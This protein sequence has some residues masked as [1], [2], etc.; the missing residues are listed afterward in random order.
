[1][2]LVEKVFSIIAP[3]DCLVCGTEGSLLCRWCL[4][5]A[6][7]PLPAQ[8]YRCH[9]LSPDSRVC[10]R[11]RPQTRLSYVW[12]RA[13][14]EDVAKQLIYELKFK[15]NLSAAVVIADLMNQ[16]LPY[17][18]PDTLIAH[19]PTST[20][21]RRQ[22]GYDQAQLIAAELGQRLERRQLTLLARL[23]H[24]QQVGS[25]RH[26]RLS[27]LTGAFRPINPRL[28]KGAE[29]LLVDDVLTTAATLQEAASTLKKA[30]AKRVTAAVFARAQ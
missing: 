28:I 9:R 23:G 27:Q 30:G 3:H 8:C 7:P 20:S 21:H 11:C 6:C 24:V 1:M 18:P 15:R 12:L 14:Y 4:P 22:R 2:R 16:A 19:V 13:D 10:A 17:L 25:K 29:I 26:E 5:D